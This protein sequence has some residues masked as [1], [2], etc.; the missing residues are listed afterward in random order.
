MKGKREFLLFNFLFSHFVCFRSVRRWK[1]K[2]GKV[3]EEAG[4]SSY[5]GEFSS[6]AVRVKSTRNPKAKRLNLDETY[7]SSQEAEE[8]DEEDDH[9]PFAQPIQKKRRLFVDR[10]KV[11]YAR[12]LIDNKLSNKEMAMLLEMS[13][14]CVRKLKLKILNGTVDELIDDSEEHYSKVTKHK[15]GQDGSSY[16]KD[17]GKLSFISYFRSMT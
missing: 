17:D 16:M 6:P 2:L 15:S 7:E 8:E 10:E 12:E 14:A 3:N 1:D 13:I 5:A 4:E 11:Q 9:E